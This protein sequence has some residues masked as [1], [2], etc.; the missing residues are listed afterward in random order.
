MSAP[1]KPAAARTPASVSMGRR[2]LS[3]KEKH[4]LE[5]LPRRIEALQ[6]NIVALGKSLSDPALF[7]RDPAAFAATAADL[8]KA[9]AAL[10]AAEEDWLRLEILRE[11]VEG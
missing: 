10:A 4:A 1:P 3:F 8:E 5:T 7:V 6:A 11:D 2:K 9:E